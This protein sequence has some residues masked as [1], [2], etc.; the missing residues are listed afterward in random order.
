MLLSCWGESSHFPERFPQEK[1]SFSS[2]Y[3]FIYLFLFPE[4]LDLSQPAQ[5]RRFITRHDDAGLPV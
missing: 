2:C 5:R 3:L 4:D 1:S